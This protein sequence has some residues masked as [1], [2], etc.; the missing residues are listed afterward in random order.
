MKENGETPNVP[1][2]LAEQGVVWARDRFIE[3]KGKEI[4]PYLK[5]SFVAC[6]A[7]FQTHR[8]HLAELIE[9]EGGITKITLRD[10]LNNALNAIICESGKVIF[11]ADILHTLVL[12]RSLTLPQEVHPGIKQRYEINIAYGGTNIGI[13]PE[14]WEIADRTVLEARNPL[15]T[16]FNPDFFP[17]DISLEERVITWFEKDSKKI[18]A[19]RDSFSLSASIWNAKLREEFAPNP[20]F[21]PQAYRVWKDESPVRAVNMIF[22]ASKP[23]PSTDGV[24]DKEMF[25]YI[26]RH[27]CIN[28]PY[29]A[30]KKL[31]RFH[32]LLQYSYQ[33]VVGSELPLLPAQLE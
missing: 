6:L 30:M 24:Y 1:E 33:K 31:K 22:T 15:R 23:G 27:G 2:G 16:F 11:S 13:N 5:S 19:T 14:D 8:K 18:L 17:Q 25:T 9:Q 3:K 7:I 26:N 10:Y 29:E 20:Y 32:E 28:D 12:S 4:E 21:D